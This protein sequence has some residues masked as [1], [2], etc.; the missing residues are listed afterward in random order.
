MTILR[1]KHVYIAIACYVHGMNIMAELK[2][3]MRIHRTNE[4]MEGWAAA[5]D[6]V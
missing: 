3:T 6:G 4:T 1:A 5:S 2:P